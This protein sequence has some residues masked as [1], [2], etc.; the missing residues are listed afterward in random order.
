[1]FLFEI[2]ALWS[3]LDGDRLFA[4]LGLLLGPQA[5]LALVLCPILGDF[6]GQE[7]ASF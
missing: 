1:M 4:V 3:S 7:R 2:L 6:L 5:C